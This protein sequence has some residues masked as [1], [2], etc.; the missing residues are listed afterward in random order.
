MPA[1]GVDVSR[2]RLRSDLPVHR[3]VAAYFKTMIALG[4]LAPGGELP[5]VSA[6]ASRFGV[7]SAH[8][9]RAFA[10]L[11]ERGLL[12]AERGRW[13]VATGDAERALVDQFRDL[14]AEGR[15]AGLPSD[16]LRELFERALQEE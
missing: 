2:F 5:A 16:R 10:E 4:H 15:R 1:G 7:S 13:R 9:R 3:Q 12:A 14:V 8:V 11:S 6:L